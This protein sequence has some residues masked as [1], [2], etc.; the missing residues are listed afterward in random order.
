MI[1]QAIRPRSGLSL[2]FPALLGLV[3]MLTGC[4]SVGKEF[5]FV[6]VPKIKA[7][8]TTI[9]DIEEMFGIPVRTGVDEGRLVYT[10]ADYYADIFGDFSG[11]DLVIKF[12]ANK[13]VYT[14]TY[15]TTDKSE[16]LAI[17]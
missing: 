10:Y 12:A 17:D 3:L 8:K 4:L 15:N 5:K 2:L 11:R 9:N 16:S 14:Y 6:D 7:G 1:F 13:T